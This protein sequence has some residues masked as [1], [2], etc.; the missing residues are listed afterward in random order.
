MPN[1]GPIFP[2]AAML[3]ENADTKSQLSVINKNIV[4]IANNKIK[5]AKY[6]ETANVTL[7]E[8]EDPLNFTGKTP[9]GNM[10]CSKDFAVNFNIKKNLTT[11]MPPPVDPPQPEVLAFIQAILLSF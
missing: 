1:P 2:N 3:A 8:Q 7:K 11:F 4:P 10:L 5:I 6:A 9:S